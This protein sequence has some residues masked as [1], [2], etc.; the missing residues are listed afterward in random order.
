MIS[1][2]LSLA[3]CSIASACNN[4]SDN[5]TEIRY[6]GTVRLLQQ[7]KTK[8]YMLAWRIWTFCPQLPPASFSCAR[9]TRPIVHCRCIPHSLRLHAGV[10]RHPVVLHGAVVWSVCELGVITAPRFNPSFFLFSLSPLQ[11]V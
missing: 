11:G 9:L 4:P 5:I 8:F 1:V 10:C 7:Q 2:I 6:L 3:K